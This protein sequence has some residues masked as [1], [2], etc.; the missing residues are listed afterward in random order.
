MIR[1]AIS[2]GYLFI[3]LCLLAVFIA[4]AG[5]LI[6]G[7]RRRS[8]RARWLGAALCASVFILCAADL[9]FDS[10][11]EWNPAIGDSQVV[12]VWTD[13]HQTLT[14]AS[15][16]TFAYQTTGG[17]ARGTWTREDWNLYLLGDSY[18]GTMRFVQFRG[19][20]RLMTHP[21]DD[22]GTW[23]GELGL[24]LDQL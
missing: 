5:A 14:L 4:G 6:W 24:R 9:A 1:T 23:D 12:G 16:Y 19:Q 13:C 11:L 15:D 10:T 22:P 17:T 20:Q 21:P 18:S 2:F 7:W 3:A 8:L